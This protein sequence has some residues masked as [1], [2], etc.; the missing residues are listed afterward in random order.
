MPHAVAEL[1]SRF[2]KTGTSCAHNLCW[3]SVQ[4]VVFVRDLDRGILGRGAHGL[5]HYEK[6]RRGT[7][8]LVNGILR[9]RRLLKQKRAA[10]ADGGCSV[11]SFCHCCCCHT[12]MAHLIHALYYVLIMCLPKS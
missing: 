1:N 9:V 4:A 7:D 11:L 6:L 12:R 3:R 5:E 8:L 10:D 2:W